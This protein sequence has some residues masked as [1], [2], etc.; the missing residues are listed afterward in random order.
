MH[1][2][3][4]GHPAVSHPTARGKT[5]INEH[6]ASEEASSVEALG[7][8]AQ[9]V[10]FYLFIMGPTGIA[11]AAC[12]NKALMVGYIPFELNSTSKERF[13]VSLI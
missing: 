5:L 1:S 3:A 2:K 11:S 6:C 12:S 13:L 10:V 8:E 7:G 4:K 9:T